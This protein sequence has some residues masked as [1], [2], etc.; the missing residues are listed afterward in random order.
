MSTPTAASDQ[1]LFTPGRIGAIEVRNRVAMAPL[2]RSRASADGVPSPLAVEYYRQR[3]S[4]GLIVAEAT[5]ISRQGRGYAWTPGIYTP[6]QVEAWK[7]V[8]DAV[9]AEGG[10][11]VLQLWHVG[12]MSHVSLQEDGAAPVAPS[13][14]QAGTVVFTEAGFEPPSAPRALSLS[15]LP[16]LVED[17]RRAAVNAKLAGFDGVE[18]HAANGYLLEQFLRDSTNR[19]TDQY[20][21]SIENRARFVLEVVDAVTEVWGADR[22]GLR[23]SPL[24]TAIGDTPIDSTPAETHGYLARKLG[25]RGLAYLH[26][27]EGQLHAGNGADAFDVEALRYAFGGA[28]IA[29]NGYDRQRALNAT[30]S[31]HADMVAF[32]KPFIGNPDLVER[33]KGNL[34]LFDAPQ[35]AYFGGGAE[36]YTQFSEQAAA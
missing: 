15:E 16:G 6:E 12:R 36:G 10:K 29:N 5:N 32:G 22:V 7:R 23:L 30:S 3:A 20:G 25:E 28:Y 4:A 19:R 2:T 11:I 35:S 13:A 33:L 1:K 14:L 9:H 18:I 21:G 27:V 8:T 17:Y 34:P 31:G 26:V 24:S